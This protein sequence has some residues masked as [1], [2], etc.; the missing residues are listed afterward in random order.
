MSETK[1]TPGP[2]AIVFG[3]S[4]VTNRGGAVADCVG[5]HPYEEQKANAALIA[6][7]P[8]MYEALESALAT[9]ESL[10]GY[11][12]EL[13]YKT[14]SANTALKHED[15]IRDALVEDQHAETPEYT[16]E[17]IKRILAKAR[18]EK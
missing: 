2:W 8:E 9:I 13:Y 5:A 10:T 16:D 11:I 4:I 6:A 3:T 17:L 18:G 15:A 7:A 14:R 1:F 12:N